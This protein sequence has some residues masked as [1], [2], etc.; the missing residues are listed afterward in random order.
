M[1][2]T[3][4]RPA[5]MTPERYLAKQPPDPRTAATAVRHHLQRVSER[6]HG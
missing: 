3:D 1:F 6:R 5:P 4:P 2:S